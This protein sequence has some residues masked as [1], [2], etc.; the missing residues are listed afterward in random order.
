MPQ[1]PLEYL[2]ILCLGLRNTLSEAVRELD[3]QPLIIWLRPNWVGGLVICRICGGMIDQSFMELSAL[4]K[5]P[6]T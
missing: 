3:L 5:E 2:T 4:L 6:A 1:Q